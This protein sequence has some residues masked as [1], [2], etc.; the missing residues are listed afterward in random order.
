MKDPIVRIRLSELTALRNRITILENRLSVYEP[1]EKQIRLLNS[2]GTPV[3]E[4]DT[5]PLYKPGP[6]SV[7][8]N[9][10]DKFTKCFAL[11]NGASKHCLKLWKNRGYIVTEDFESYEKTDRYKERMRQA[12]LKHVP[13]DLLAEMTSK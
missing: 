12:R 5:H 7:L 1:P 2:D 11:N 3:R 6:R 4:P 9:F 13:S 10:P 8:E